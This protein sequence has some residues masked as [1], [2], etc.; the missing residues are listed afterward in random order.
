[1]YIYLIIL[2]YIYISGYIYYPKRNMVTSLYALI[3]F[4]SF[5]RIHSAV[6]G[7][8]SETT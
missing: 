4:P 6:I 5:W 3:G 7:S 8:G 2:N 1:M